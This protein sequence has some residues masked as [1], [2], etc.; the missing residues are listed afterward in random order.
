MIKTRDSYRLNRKDRKEVVTVP[1]FEKQ[2][3]LKIGRKYGT[4]GL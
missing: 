4:T 1:G 3:V 2:N